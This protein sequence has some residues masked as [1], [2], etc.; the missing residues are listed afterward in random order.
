MRLRTRQI[1]EGKTKLVVPDLAHYGLPEHAP[2][3][4]NPAMATDR[5]NSVNILR[6]FFANR[7]P[8]TVTVADALCGTGARAARYARECGFIVQ[9]NDGQPSAVKLASRNAKLNKVKIK[10]SRCEANAFLAQHRHEFDA[11][12]VDPFGSPAPFL[13]NAVNALKPSRSLLMLT[14]TDTGTLS[15][16]FARA[17]LNRYGAITASTS[18]AAEVGLRNLLHAVQ[19]HASVHDLSVAPVAVFANLHY[20]RVFLKLG[21]EPMQ[22]NSGFITYCRACERRS[23]HPALSKLKLKCEC[24]RERALLGPTWI[25]PTT[26]PCATPFYDLQLLCAK[27]KKQPARKQDVIEKLCK[28]GWPSFATMLSGQGVVTDAPYEELVKCLR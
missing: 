27:L 19:R 21:Y 13:A 9:A 8:K 28:R 24:G 2:V 3:F 25:G 10:T 14:A 1:T 17:C 5:T 15:G 11:V 26:T 22:K 20:Y 6:A 23:L 12:D 18:F 4:Y 7:K 16:A